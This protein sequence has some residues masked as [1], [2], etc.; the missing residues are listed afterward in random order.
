MA[1]Y[2]SLVVLALLPLLVAS[3]AEATVPN[4]IPG[5]ATYQ[6][7]TLTIRLKSGRP[8]TVIETKLKWKFLTTTAPVT[9]YPTPNP[10]LTTTAVR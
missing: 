1:T 5:G 9:C 2:R 4:A 8:G 3:E 6:L 7:P 10:P